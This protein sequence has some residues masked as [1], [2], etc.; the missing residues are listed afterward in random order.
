MYSKAFFSI[1]EPESILFIVLVVC[2]LFY[3]CFIDLIQYTLASESQKSRLLAVFRK[4]TFEC[5]EG[6]AL[7]RGPVGGDG[8]NRFPSITCSCSF[9]SITSIPALTGLSCQ[10]CL[11][12]LI[13]CSAYFYNRLHEH[14]KGCW[15]ESIKLSQCTLEFLAEKSLYIFL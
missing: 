2:G 15:H 14:F 9:P 7:R 1:T 5:F 11:F 12:A 6:I 4:C 3:L 8:M 13:K 10:V